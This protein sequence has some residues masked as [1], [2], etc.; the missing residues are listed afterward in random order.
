MK[1]LVVPAVEGNAEVPDL[2]GKVDSPIQELELPR[3]VQLELISLS[4]SWSI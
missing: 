2:G 1:Q 4:Q 3:L